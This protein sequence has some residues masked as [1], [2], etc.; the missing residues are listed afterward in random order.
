[1]SL[2]H[3]LSFVAF[4][5][6]PNAPIALRPSI[7]WPLACAAALVLTAPF[8]GALSAPL[9]AQSIT[10]AAISGTVRAADGRLVAQALVTV[11]PVG[12]GSR[13]ETTTTSSGTFTLG[14]IQPGSYEIRVEALGYRPVVA[15]VLTLGGGERRDVSL[16]LNPAPPPVLTVDT[17]A[18][19]AGASTRWRAGGVQLGGLELGLPYRYDDLASIASLSTAF[20]ESMGA[21]GLP[22]DMTL[23]VADGVPFYRAQHPTARAELHP[24]AL[25]PRQSLSSV[26]PLHA[27]SDVGWAGS[28]GGYVGVATRSST[29]DGGVELEGAYSSD[30]TWSSSELDFDVPSL[31]SYQGAL[32]G[33]VPITPG[34]S[35]ITLSGEALQQQTPLV[36]RI[37]EMVASNLSGLDAD[38]L[39]SLSEPAVE[40]YARYSGLARLDLQRSSTSNVFF[41][42]LGAYAVREFEGAG[43]ASL[44]PGAAP[45]E[46]SIDYTLAGGIVSDY[47][48]RLQL[49]LQGGVS[50]STRD[51]G[52]AVDA[53]PGAY[54]ATTASRLG[55]LSVAPGESSR[56][57]FVLLPSLRYMLRGGGSIKAGV[58]AR[59]ASHSMAY[60]AV[61]SEQFLYSDE[62][63]LMA[64]DGF[65]RTTSAPEESFSTQEVGVYAQYQ[66]S[67]APGL[68]VTLGGRYDLERIKSDGPT[69]NP[70]WLAASGLAND[71]YPWRFQQVGARGTLTW[72]PGATGD[73]RL[74]LTGSLHEG[75]IDP[76][77]VYE[78]LSR[79]AGTTSTSFSGAGVEWPAATLPGGATTLPTLTLLGPDTRAPR[80]IHLGAGI[81]QRV[82]PSLALFLRGSLRRTDFLMRRR[83]LNVPPV[84][85][86]SDPNGRA[87]YGTL[88]QNGAL[89][90]ATGADA[91]RF[92]AF[93]DV[94]ALDPDGWSEYLGFTFGLEHSSAAADL[95]GSYTYSETTD[96][97]VGAG[98]GSVEAEFRPRLPETDGGE[99]SEGVSDFD[100]PH[101]VAAG[102][103][104]RFGAVAVSGAYRFRSGLPFTPR[105]RLG[106]DANGDGSVANDVAFVSDAAT[107]G[108]LAE[109]W[110]CLGDQAGGFAVRN[111]CRGPE[112]HSVDA[113]VEVSLG[114]LGGRTA[115][116]TLDGF[117]L[118]EG[119]GGVID[120]ALLLVDPSGAITTDGST[121]TI[122]VEVNPSFGQVLYPSS[123]GRML[124]VGVRIGG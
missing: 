84:A 10:S 23:V 32:R 98:A 93:G 118:V 58:S 3:D 97:W 74:L 26:M 112:Q 82:R 114:R 81:M 94:W 22:G 106:V 40:T 27:A 50:G 88:E 53:V 92:P 96:N 16:T 110:S 51:F 47:S 90:T 11:T 45:A 104:L 55:N 44:S 85:Q 39:S 46:E 67:L 12:T 25:F 30:A 48:T 35:Q 101:R 52:T 120:D 115:R 43:P 18:L 24:D 65:A 17:V 28:A 102:L 77:V 79:D 21:Q 29:S 15:R 105:Y 56:T 33:T 111:S 91:R 13:Y 83:N 78:L 109:E 36:P 107:L 108:A 71:D 8:S 117:N 64:S 63:A 19:G 60:S 124:R 38:L 76:R 5:V 113:R 103:T 41:R 68:R 123:R 6:P 54:L 122:P 116:L 14:L 59:I 69:P 61:P 20:D 62:A 86:A 49:E 34:V 31:L 99:W 2:P 89:I 42:G 87:I 37:S 73:T 121:V 66:T 70:D 7:S 75:D 95:Y 80:T 1:M 57:D 9:R 119:S 4:V 72:E 100:V